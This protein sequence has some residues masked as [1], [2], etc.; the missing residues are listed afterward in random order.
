MSEL[1]IDPSWR[2]RSTLTGV[3]LPDG[4]VS[5]GVLTDPEAGGL[6]V[7]FDDRDLDH[8][9]RVVVAYGLV[10]TVTGVRHG[11]ITGQEVT[12]LRVRHSSP[13]H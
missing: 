12:A 11:T 1:S 2:D 8:G 9:D 4:T 6:L 13:G 7:L 5:G 10:L 3:R